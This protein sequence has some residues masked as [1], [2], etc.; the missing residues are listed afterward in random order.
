MRRGSFYGNGRKYPL[1]S[2][3]NDGLES[4]FVYTSSRMNAI[5]K[6]INNTCY[7]VHVK[8]IIVVYILYQP[9]AISLSEI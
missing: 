8:S 6:I 5:Q 9:Q 7:K 1:V 4:A 3:N 2:P